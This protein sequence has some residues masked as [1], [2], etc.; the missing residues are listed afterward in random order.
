MEE[1]LPPV[2]PGGVAGWSLLGRSGGAAVSLFGGMLPVGR[3]RWACSVGAPGELLRWCGSG[4][5]WKATGRIAVAISPP[6]TL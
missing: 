5:P 4:G 3:L 2:N 6:G 1:M